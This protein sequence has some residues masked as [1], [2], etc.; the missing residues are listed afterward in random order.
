MRLPHRPAT[1][2][3]FS[4][5]LP[6][7]LL[8][9]LRAGAQTAPA[10]TIRND[11]P[12]LDVNGDTVDVHDGRIARFGDRYYWYGTAYGTTTGFTRANEY[13]VY[14]A[15]SLAGPWTPHGAILPDAPSGV[16]YRPHVIHDA[17]RDRYVLWYNWYPKLWDGYFGVAVSDSPTGPFRIADTDV[18]VAH[19]ALGVGDFNLFVDDDGAGYLMYNTIEGHRLSVERL[20]D[21]YLASTLDNGGFIA[22]HCEAGSVFARGGTYY[23]LTDYTC[24]FCTQGS[25]ARVYTSDSPLGPYALRQNINRVPGTPAPRLTDGDLRPTVYHA[26]RRGAPAD[27]AAF[28]AVELSLPRAAP[29]GTLRVVQYAGNRG[30]QCGDTL[31]ARTHEPRVVAAFSVE[32]RV[33][34][35]WRPVA[36]ARAPD[37]ARTTLTSAVAVDLGGLVADGLR[38]AFDA[39]AYPYAAVQLVE[40]ALADAEGRPLAAREGTYAYVLDRDPQHTPPIVPAQQT[41]VMPL[42]VAGGRTEYL[43]MGDL[44]GSAPDDVKG[45]DQQYW[46]SPLE[47]YANGLIRPLRWED[48]W[49][50]PPAD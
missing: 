14:S 25:G 18:R 8:A 9:G 29:L 23:L 40:T 26:L 19:S 33:G 50:L 7:A 37:T 12:R 45:H 36:P 34:G 24:C 17:R 43:W 44:W 6:I 39:E 11:A 22:D 31:A 3:A 27:S 16:Y 47:F 2:L 10:P 41:F 28:P 48:S 5:L 21:D 35:A 20:A 4:L 30:G 1:R 15:P 42:P 46:S 13:R 32:A 38:V 49:T